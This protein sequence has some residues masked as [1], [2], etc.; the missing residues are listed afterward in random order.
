M[1]NEKLIHAL[2]MLCKRLYWKIEVLAAVENC[3]LQN[4]ASYEKELL[5]TLEK[6]VGLEAWEH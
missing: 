6:E 4:F 1:S 3:N 5:I 2:L